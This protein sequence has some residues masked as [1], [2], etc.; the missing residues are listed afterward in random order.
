MPPAPQIEDWKSPHVQS[1]F[2]RYVEW[3]MRRWIVGHY[4]DIGLFAL[5]AL[6]VISK[7]GS[8]Q[9][10]HRLHDDILTINFVAETRPPKT[11]PA[12]VGYAVMERELKTTVDYRHRVLGVKLLPDPHLGAGED[13]ERAKRNGTQLMNIVMYCEPVA[14]Q[15]FIP[16]PSQL[17]LQ[18]MTYDNK[19]AQSFEDLSSPI[20]AEM[21]NAERRAS[22]LSI[23]LSA[24]PVDPSLSLLDSK[25]LLDRWASY[26]EGPMRA[27]AYSALGL[28]SDWTSGSRH[29][30]AIELEQ[31][32]DRAASVHACYGFTAISC[33]K[34]ALSDVADWIRS[35]HA[36]ES[37]DEVDRIVSSV[38]GRIDE[39]KQH[40][41]SG[42]AVAVVL[43]YVPPKPVHPNTNWLTLGHDFPIGSV[44]PQ[45]WCV[46][47]MFEKAFLDEY[48][49]GGHWFDVPSVPLFQKPF[50]RNAWG[51]LTF[52]RDGSAQ[53]FPD[54]EGKKYFMMP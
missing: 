17:E 19:Y 1:S 12:P 28:H 50:K 44:P 41:V 11:V 27:V 51:F 25:T 13:V 4:S 22:V 34:L 9:L 16:I 24:R 3:E 54:S 33:Q 18:K 35:L 23:P 49:D 32:T 53:R 48:V 7:P 43:L 45:A 6:A 52:G 46:D 37:S 26:Y 8:S 47:I 38:V 31:C 21:F 2:R 14:F 36:S 29:T 42:H 10:E 5:H 30:F 20:V 39:S 15:L 40:G